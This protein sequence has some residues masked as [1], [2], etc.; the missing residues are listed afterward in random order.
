MEAEDP[1]FFGLVLSTHRPKNMGIDAT[2]YFPY[3]PLIAAISIV[4]F[5]TTVSFQAEPLA[6]K[7]FFSLLLAFLAYSRKSY[8]LITA[9]ELFSYSVPYLLI[10]RDK[11]G[12]QA[13]TRLLYISG[14]A[15]VSLLLVHLAANGSLFRLFVWVT[16]NLVVRSMKHLIPVDEMV[17]AY[18]I[19]VAFLDERILVKQLRHLFFVTFHIQVGMG[20]L[21]IDFLRKEQDRR[22]QL[23][24]MDVGST[25]GK[26]RNGVNRDSE[27]M[28]ERARQ[29]QR[30]A[31]AFILLTALPYMSQII[32][33]GNV[34]KFAFM[35]VL[36]DL[37]RTV[38]LSELFDHD[39][40][41]IAMANESPTT[42]EGML[43]MFVGSGLYG[44]ASLIRLGYAT[45]MNTVVS[46]A[47]EIF[48]RKMF[49]LPKVLL[50]PSVMS[51]Q[52]MLVAQVFP[53]IILSDWLKASAVAFMTRKI[54]QLERELQEIR[55][56]RTK[57]ESF[58]IKNAELLQRSGK[59]ATQF[60]QRRWEALTTKVHARVVISDLLSRSKGFF[61]FI[62]RNFVFSVLI[63]C[64]LANLIALGKIV[65]ND[66]FVFS[67]AIEDAVDMILMRSRG[68]AELARMD[69]EIRKLRDLS[70]IWERSKD[71]SLLRCNLA[72][73]PGDGL[74]LRNLLYSRGTANVRADHIELKAGVYALTGS[75]GS[76][77]SDGNS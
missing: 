18:E 69:T 6:L 31:P 30:S 49:S 50:L 42:P 58:D 15:L 12:Q 63:D 70:D 10:V 29:F 61:A 7:W 67:R 20:Y 3:E 38:R 25:E 66:T 59:G 75:N 46:T 51:K 43:I 55:A 21:G 34:N 4:F 64:A 56:I 73:S 33:Y 45:S 74:V 47:Y 13:I 68:E 14:S 71:R 65:S 22:N 32:L 11:F 72:Q 17:E 52:P 53:F 26:K 36:H 24:R 23:V 1:T 77:K 40:H 41:L 5:R 27:A 39:R 62:Q 19:M 8:E 57:V 44:L 9:V 35:C 28:M 2:S 54:E 76:G 16:P 37:H 48:N 60:T